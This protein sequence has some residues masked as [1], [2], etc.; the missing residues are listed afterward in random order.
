MDVSCSNLLREDR[1]NHLETNRVRMDKTAAK[2][3]L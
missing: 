2:E 3:T 1:V